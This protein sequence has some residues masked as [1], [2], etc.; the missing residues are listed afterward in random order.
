MRLILPLVFVAVLSGSVAAN[1]PPPVLKL[2]PVVPSAGCSGGQ[3]PAPAKVAPVGN[4]GVYRL[5]VVERFGERRPVRRLVAAPLRRL[6]G[7]CR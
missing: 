1:D 3:C 7:G 2:T 6:F 4:R 5:R